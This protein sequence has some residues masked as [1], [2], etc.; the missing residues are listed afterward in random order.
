MD[1]AQSVRGARRHRR[2]HLVRGTGRPGRATP[3]PALGHASSPATTL[4]GWRSAASTPCASRS[5]T[6]FSGRIIPITAATATAAI[7]L[8]PVASRCSTAPSIGPRISVCASCSI[9]TPRPA[10]RT[11]ST[12]AASRMS[13]SGTRRRI[14]ASTRCRCWS[15]WPSAIT[16]MRRCMPSRC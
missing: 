14:T 2:D 8:S 5:G 16:A 13:A 3:A 4:S 15:G 12:T 6:G 9:C 1:G 11:A 10:A 7:R